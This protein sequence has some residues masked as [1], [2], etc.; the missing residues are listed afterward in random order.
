MGIVFSLFRRILARLADPNDKKSIESEAKTID[1]KNL[2]VPRCCT[3]LKCTSAASVAKELL[4]K[5]EQIQTQLHNEV[6]L[7]KLRFVRGIC[8][9][10]S[11]QQLYILLKQFSVLN[12]MLN[13]IIENETEYVS[14]SYDHGEECT[15][16]KEL[17]GLWSKSVAEQ[18]NDSAVIK[19]DKPEWC[20]TKNEKAFNKRKIF[21]AKVQDRTVKM[22]SSVLKQVDECRS[23]VETTCNEHEL[24][25]NFA[26]TPDN[27][28][29]TSLSIFENSVKD[30]RVHGQKKETIVVVTS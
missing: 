10:E 5:M 6:V 4:T 9:E 28:G 8:N 2:V 30:Q 19:P 12:G 3:D 25:E 13:T 20:A 16:I 23:I 15:E 17:E 26:L 11:R 1:S 7:W 14:V 18:K 21:F 24:S 27:A 29:I 22:L